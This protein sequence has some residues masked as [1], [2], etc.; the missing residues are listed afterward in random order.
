MKKKIIQHKFNDWLPLKSEIG[1]D[2]KAIPHFEDN[3]GKYKDRIFPQF[4][5]ANIKKRFNRQIF[6]NELVKYNSLKKN[7]Y[8][9]DII[10]ALIKAL[11]ADEELKWAFEYD[12]ILPEY[13]I[14]TSLYTS[15]SIFNN[16]DK[17]LNFITIFRCTSVI[18]ELSESFETCFG[19]LSSKK[20][21]KNFLIKYSSN[22]DGSTNCYLIKEF[23]Y[24]GFVKEISK[25]VNKEI[26][27]EIKIIAPDNIIL[28]K[29]YK[30]EIEK[31]LKILKPLTKKKRE[32]FL[33]FVSADDEDYEEKQEQQKLTGTYIYILTPQQI[34]KQISEYK[35]N[36]SIM[37]SFPIK[38]GKPD[39]SADS[40]LHYSS[41]ITIKAN[42]FI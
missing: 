35:M 12:E 32:D 41:K 28:N 21:K 13:D 18:L 6:L 16:L 40:K 10:L 15:G 37:F 30:F 36:G 14:I 23:K 17:D 24:K 4:T 33:I 1:A 7:H 34:K 27:K 26:I 8:Y 20:D 3:G 22:R 9:K 29:D 39:L 25:I 11:N 5:L 2:G 38:R 31:I 42:H 19:L